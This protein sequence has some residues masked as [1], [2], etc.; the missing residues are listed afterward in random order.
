MS[1][2]EHANV[3]VSP[4]VEE[5]LILAGDTM[6]MDV[7][8]PPSPEFPDARYRVYYM[9]RA[10]SGDA[11]CAPDSAAPSQCVLMTPCGVEKRMTPFGDWFTPL[12]SEALAGAKTVTVDGLRQ[13]TR[14]SFT[15]MMEASDGRREVMTGTD[16]TP[17]STRGEWPAAWGLTGR[18]R[19]PRAPR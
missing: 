16:A 1:I 11:V 8:F 17:H 18:P 13:D 14:Y 15:V 10:T 9:E 7:T 5:K 3:T 6:S 4:S 12:P 19:A 2:T